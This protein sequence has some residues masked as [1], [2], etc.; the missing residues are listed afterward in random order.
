MDTAGFRYFL[1]VDLEATC[2]D[3]GSVPRREM[4]TIEIG[5]VLVDAQTLVAV[6]EFDRFVRPVRHPQLTA[7]CTRLT[8]IT[9]QDLDGAALFPQ[10]L[11]EFQ[12]WFSAYRSLLFCSWGEYDKNQ[13]RQDCSYHGVSYPFGDTHWNIKQAFCDAQGLKKG[14]GMRRALTIAG[15]QLEGRHHRGID[16]A[17]N[18][19]RLMPW[20]LGRRT[21]PVQP[22]SH[23]HHP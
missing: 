12:H 10:V 18:M 22:K 8:G 13:L 15:L 9:Q 6:A 16:D 20:I 1:I 19:V 23:D 14:C 21:E 4:E 5:A 3:R 11:A 17:R 2:C 7:F